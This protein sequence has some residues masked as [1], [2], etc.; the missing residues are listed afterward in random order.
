MPALYEQYRP[1]EW[2]DVVG[3]DKTLARI[4]RLRK[5]GLGGRVYWITGSSGSGKT[6]IARILADEINP[7]WD[8]V[9]IDGADLTLD[10]VREFERVC[11]TPLI[12][13]RQHVFITNE[14]HAMR[15]PV[16]RRL[17]TTFERVEV[18]RNSTWLFTTTTDGQN[19]L[20]DDEIEEGPFSSRCIALPLS[21]RGLADAFAT[22]AREIATKEGLN[23][24]P[25]DAYLRLAKKHKNNLR[26]MLQA[27]DAGEMLA[28]VEG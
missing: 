20:F 16:I 28:T 6:T 13:G 26:S 15:S 2:S 25:I 12:G 1:R 18:Q 24:K 17:N 22:R 4:D 7:D 5:R 11:R 23:G 9:E 27:I 8:P 21:R 3:Q 14:A 19:S 10:R